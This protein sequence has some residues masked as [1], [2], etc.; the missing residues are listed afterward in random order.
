MSKVIPIALAAHYDLPATTL[1]G[2]LKVVRSDG[3][4][5]GLTTLDVS[6]DV[7]GVTYF[8]GLELNDIVSTA[9][10]AVDNTNLTVIPDPLDD[11]EYADDIRAKRW[12]NA[13]FEIFR[14]NY[15]SIGDGVDYLKSGTTGDVKLGEGAY[16]LEFRGLTQALQQTLG[17]S[18]SITCRAALA[19]Y[20]QAN[21]SALCRL[22][23]SDWTEIGVV[24]SVTNNRVFGDATRTEPDEWFEEGFLKFT[25]SDGLNIGIEQRVRVFAGGIFTLAEAMPFEVQVGDEYQVIAGCKKRHERRL[26][27]TVDSDGGI[28]DCI[29]KFDNILNFQ[30]E[31]F[32]PGQD[33]IT[34]APSDV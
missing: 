2:C 20:P 25:G 26:G 1:A 29:D 9:S 14:V 11:S 22:D 34:A 17:I 30:G 15:K 32:M 4:V 21:G 23:P 16:V 24:D 27:I 12:N 28:S 13:F 8:P 18:T 3:L 5:V 10:L 31:P 19:D 7:G 6:I 33:K